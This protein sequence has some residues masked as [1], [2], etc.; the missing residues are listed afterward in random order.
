LIRGISIGDYRSIGETQTIEPLGKINL[1][2][3]PN[4]SGKSNVLRFINENLVPLMMQIQG[5]RLSLASHPHAHRGKPTHARVA[6]P[7]SLHA[8]QELLKPKGDRM[9]QLVASIH[10]NLAPNDVL[11][12]DPQWPTREFIQDVRKLGEPDWETLWKHL[13]PGVSGGSA[14]EHWVP[15]VLKRFKQFAIK[16]TVFAIPIDRVAGNA[17]SGAS[18]DSGTHN[19]VGGRSVIRTLAAMQSPQ[20]TA[21][22]TGRNQF[23]QIQDFVRTVTDDRTAE[24]SVPHTQDAI[25]V[26]FKG[27]KYFPLADLGSG[28]EQVVLHA[29]AATSITDA[30]VT[31][32]EPELHLHPVLQR[33]LMTYLAKKTSNQYFISTH[34]AHMIDALHA[35][36]FHVRLLNGQSSIERAQTDAER[37]RICQDLGYRASDIIQ[38]NC[39]IWV[40]GPSDRIYIKYWL[41]QVDCDLTEQVHFSIMF[42][43]GKLLSH[44]SASETDNV[45][46]GLE[47]LIHLRL[48]NRHVCVVMDSDLKAAADEI[49]ATKA[50]VR[51]EIKG[52]GGLVWITAGKELENYV[53]PSILSAAVE[54]VAPGYGS[55][56]KSGQFKQALPFK[57]NTKTVVDKVGTAREVVKAGCPLDRFNL[58]DRIEELSAFIRKANSLPQ[59]SLTP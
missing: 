34:S 55:A 10:Q 14:V 59:R 32:E 52:N 15:E 56:V 1:L 2:V 11:W 3:G 30:I 58:E 29:V 22:E 49:R 6:V 44:L 4:N 33:Q 57:K 24:I 42:Y 50:R 19:V 7:A 39:I 36:T 46:D 13:Y 12:L 38:A 48:L 16:M 9:R 45:D 20:H 18:S 53:S 26:R 23:E 28:I 5:E 8:I 43:G 31:F 47:D 21:Y 17:D 51:D 40:E 37:F 54:L 27:Q 25:N 35:E 41:A